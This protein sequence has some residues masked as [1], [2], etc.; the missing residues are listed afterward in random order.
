MPLKQQPWPREALFLLQVLIWIVLVQT[1]VIKRQAPPAISSSSPSSASSSSSSFEEEEE[2][3]PEDLK[4]VFSSDDSLRL[5]W[6]FDTSSLK[7]KEAE[8][9]EEKEKED[10]LTPPPNSNDTTTSTEEKE[11]RRRLTGY[12]IFYGH[13]AYEDVKTIKSNIDSFRYE[14]TGLGKKGKNNPSL[15]CMGFLHVSDTERNRWKVW[16]CCDYFAAC[17]QIATMIHPSMSSVW[18]FIT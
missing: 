3:R 8:R 2:L 9:E 6:T 18:P 4:V 10:I 12:R 7:G 15:R 14:L 17:L 1:S 11:G 13:G 5:A 16:N